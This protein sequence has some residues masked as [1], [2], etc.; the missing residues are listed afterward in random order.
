VKYV[1][2]TELA[3]LIVQVAE[4]VTAATPAEGAAYRLPPVVLDVIALLP[5]GPQE[6]V[7]PG[8]IPAPEIVI[9]EVTTPARTLP[10][11]RVVED[12]GVAVEEKK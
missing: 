9:P 11:I 2:G 4:E 8:A 5:I 1:A 10:T 3:T 7:V 6:I 12:T